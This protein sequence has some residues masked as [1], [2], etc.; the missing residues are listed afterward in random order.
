MKRALVVVFG[1]V[2]QSPRMMNHAKSLSDEGYQVDVIGYAKDTRGMGDEFKCCQFWNV[3][4]FHISW[5]PFIIR[6][7]I[8]ILLRTLF[9]LW[10]G[11]FRISRPDII[12]V[13]NPPSLPT[14]LVSPLLAAYHKARYII[15]WHNFGF[16]ILGIGR[17]PESRLVSLAKK[18]ELFL[19]KYGHV[20]LTVSKAMKVWLVENTGIKSDSVHVLY[21]RPG[22]RFHH[23]SLADKHAYL[24]RLYGSFDDDSWGD[25]S[26]STTTDYRTGE[27]VMRPMA[28]RSSALVVSSTSWTAD[29]DFGLLWEAIKD[30]DLRI[31]KAGPRKVSLF[32]TIHLLITGKGPLRSYYENLFS[33][34]KLSFFKIRTAWLSA[35]DYASLL[36]CADLG[37]SLHKSSSGLDIPMKAIDMLGSGLPVLAY[38]YPAINELIEEE[39]NGILFEDSEHL[40]DL[41]LDLFHGFPKSSKV[42]KSMADHLVLKPLPAWKGHWNKIVRDGI[43][44]KLN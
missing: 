11:I 2:A 29:E 33:S 9:F 5:L 36:A 16:T 6:A 35:D 38:K 43:L 15:D 17:K 30:A 13:Q 37:I 24:T 3:P 31:A 41:L 20:H 28:E 34:E 40:S 27:V 12:I 19:G 14:L 22:H 8:A 25:E 26:P 10:T 7:A 44:A 42:I 32:P 18:I 4:R 1:D 23:L 39:E 21:D